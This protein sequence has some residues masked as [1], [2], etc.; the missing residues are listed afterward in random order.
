MAT[1]YGA[2]IISGQGI[3]LRNG[4]I[5]RSTVG[6]RRMET[7]RQQ[8]DSAGRPAGTR[9]PDARRMRAN[10]W[11]REAAVA[12]IDPAPG[13]QEVSLA[14]DLEVVAPADSPEIAAGQVGR[15]TGSAAGRAVQIDQEIGAV[16]IALGIDKFQVAAEAAAHSAAR[17][18]A[19]PGLARAGRAALPV[20]AGRAAAAVSAVAE[21]DGERSLADD[22]DL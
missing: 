1:R 4:N 6:A 16:A 5:I 17:A 19:E 7:E 22:H 9:Q 12:A 15:E 8:T 2:A 10:K 18:V 14:T 11:A 3:D 20:S 21:G 13:A